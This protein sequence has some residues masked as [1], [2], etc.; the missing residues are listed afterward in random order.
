MNQTKTADALAQMTSEQL[1]AP[2]FGVVE[3]AAA[4]AI[5]TYNAGET[6]LSGRQP[7]KSHR[8]KFFHTGRA[9]QRRARISRQIR[10]FD[11]TPFG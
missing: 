7:E 9:A 8:Q 5:L 1:D 11:R 6:E 10:R 2:P 3:L 4:G